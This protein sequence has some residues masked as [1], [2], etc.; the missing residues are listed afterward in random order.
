MLFEEMDDFGIL[1][2]FS[3]P[4]KRR[5]II[6]RAHVRFC[7]PLQQ[8]PDGAGVLAFVGNGQHEGRESPR[9]TRFGCGALVQQQLDHLGVSPFGGEEQGS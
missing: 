2:P 9:I 4:G 7:A 8:K 1:A 6:V 5:L 3:R